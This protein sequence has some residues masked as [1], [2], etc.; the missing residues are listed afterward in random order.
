MGKLKFYICLNILL[1]LP[2]YICNSLEEKYLKLFNS[3]D[4]F[5]SNQN[6]SNTIVSIILR[7]SVCVILFTYRHQYERQVLRY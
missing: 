3:F 1:F 5:L 6:I 4:I 2:T 7:S